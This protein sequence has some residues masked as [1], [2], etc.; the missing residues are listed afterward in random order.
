[1][2]ASVNNEATEAGGVKQLGTGAERN[3]ILSWLQLAAGAG[4]A[5]KWSSGWPQ[6]GAE[7]G[8]A[9]NWSRKDL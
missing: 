7:A 3:W 6:Q 8:A 9:R 4:A 5:S 2:E 1:M